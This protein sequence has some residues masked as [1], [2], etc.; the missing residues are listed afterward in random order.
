MASSGTI[1][2][3]KG[4]ARYRR[5]WPNMPGEMKPS[6]LSIT[7]A[8]ARMVPELRS[9][10]L[11][12]KSMLPFQRYSVSSC[13]RIS[14]WLLR[15]SL[16]ARRYFSSADSGAS[17]TKRIGF[18]LTMVVSTVVSAA[19]RLPGARR[20]HE[21]RPAIGALMR[22]YDEVQ[23]VRWSC[24]A[25]AAARLAAACSCAAARRSACAWLTSLSLISDFGALQLRVGIGQH[26]ASRLPRQ[27]GPCAICASK[28]R[29]SMTNSSWPFCTLLAILEVHGLDGTGHA[30]PHFHRCPRPRSGRS[31]HPSP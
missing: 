5:S 21:A 27:R 30:G 9:S 29:G 10:A 13:R 25:S 4:P 14:T 24:A 11:S 6:G 16:P 3:S 19:T 17:N 22:V 18:S 20:R 1:S 26:G 23:F 2:A 7:V 12:M 28:G 31:S 8:R 15:W